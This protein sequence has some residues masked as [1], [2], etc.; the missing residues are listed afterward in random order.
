M[1]F[2]RHMSHD[3]RTPINGIRGLLEVARRAPNDMQ[4]QTYCR[5]KIWMISGTLLE[6][7]NDVLDMSKL[8]SGGERLESVPFDIS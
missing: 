5:E 7:V 6:L 3:V 4:R 1:Q 2:L 8:D